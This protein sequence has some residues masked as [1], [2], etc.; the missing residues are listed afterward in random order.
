MHSMLAPLTAQRQIVHAQRLTP[1]HLLIA[2]RL[3]SRT[4]GFMQSVSLRY[5]K[6]LPSR[7]ATLVRVAASALLAYH[8]ILLGAHQNNSVNNGGS[9][10]RGDARRHVIETL[11]HLNARVVE[12]LPRTHALMFAIGGEDPWAVA[13]GQTRHQGGGGWHN[14]DPAV[15]ADDDEPEQMDESGDGESDP[16]PQEAKAILEEQENTVTFPLHDATAIIYET[17]GG[18]GS[19]S[20]QRF[21]F[22]RTRIPHALPTLPPQILKAMASW[23]EA[24]EIHG[25]AMAYQPALPIA[26]H[27]SPLL[28]LLEN[29]RMAQET[30]QQHDARPPTWRARYT[31]WA[32]SCNELLQWVALATNGVVKLMPGLPVKRYVDAFERDGSTL[33]VRVD[34]DLD[35]LYE[36]HPPDLLERFAS[37]LEC[38]ALQYVWLLESLLWHLLVEPYG[39][40][41][42]PLAQV[43]TPTPTAA[44][45]PAAEIL[46]LAMLSQESASV[47]VRDAKAFFRAKYKVSA[48]AR[49][50]QPRLAL[51]DDSA[52]LG[53][54]AWRGYIPREVMLDY[55]YFMDEDGKLMG[56]N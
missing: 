52:S 37:L 2:Q 36:Q 46:S 56:N 39:A 23:Q 25:S 19:G 21:R 47:V 24:S 51:L 14:T 32:T 30:S 42:V 10:L 48:S 3:G 27:G 8:F 17:A 7:R 55:L 31:S 13:A 33:R 45:A 28:S 16:E 22:D 44:A 4:T 6:F 34:E 38:Y 9:R 12:G 1:T 20:G 41:A 49:G 43:L 26:L 5:Q 50:F 53:T 35:A 18:G 54:D 29:Q 40:A 11:V 15:D